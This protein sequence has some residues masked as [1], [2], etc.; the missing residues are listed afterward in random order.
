MRNKIYYGYNIALYIFW[1]I[2]NKTKQKIQHC[3]NQL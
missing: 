2:K 1:M 3:C